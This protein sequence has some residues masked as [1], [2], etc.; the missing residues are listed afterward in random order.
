ML[1]N[2][3][4]PLLQ[5]CACLVSPAMLVEMSR[6]HTKLGPLPQGSPANNIRLLFLVFLFSYRPGKQRNYFR[7][8]G[9]Q[10]KDFLFQ[11]NK[12]KTTKYGLSSFFFLGKIWA[13]LKGEI[14]VSIQKASLLDALLQFSVCIIT[15][16]GAPFSKST[17]S[18]RRC[19]QLI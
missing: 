8:R 2:S 17:G 15:A 1:I 16:I 10:V 7:R 14:M 19:C 12:R 6:W 5:I 11:G 3:T 9:G 13:F 18:L 4:F